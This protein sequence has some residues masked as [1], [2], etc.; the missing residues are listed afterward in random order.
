MTD[1]ALPLLCVLGLLSLSTACYI[2]N[3]PRGGKRS[4]PDPVSRQCMTCGPGDRGRCFGPS[5][6]CGEDIGCLLGS[7]E[8]ANCLEEDYLPSPC[9]AGG[10]V[11]GSDEGRC[12]APGVCCD[13]EGCVLDPDCTDDNKFRAL[14]E[15]KSTLMDTS[16]GKLLLQILH[17]GS[18]ARTQF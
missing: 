5:I 1:S 13:S 15:Q 9:E 16:P 11:C 14:A 6:C 18:R 8:T 10:K 17:P 7:P 4:F 12:A 3:C 2:Q